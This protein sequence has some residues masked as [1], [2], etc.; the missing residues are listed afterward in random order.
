MNVWGEQ[1]SIGISNKWEPWMNIWVE[2]VVEEWISTRGTY[3][4]WRIRYTHLLFPYNY[5][6]KYMN[7]PQ[8]QCNAHADHS[9]I[10]KQTTTT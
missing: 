8:I 6:S 7:K 4:I 10:T 9:N 2:S 3:S 1:Q 5:K